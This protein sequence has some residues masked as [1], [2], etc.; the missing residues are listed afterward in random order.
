[1]QR[2]SGHPV[3]RSLSVNQNCLRDTGSPAFAG[4]DQ[5]EQLW[6]VCSAGRNSA[7]CYCEM[8]WITL[9][10]GLALVIVVGSFESWP[11]IASY[12]GSDSS[13]PFGRIATTL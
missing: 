4:D 8:V 2:G 5:L 7:G 12:S 9:D 13:V 11:I 1:M 3:C 10:S 6:P